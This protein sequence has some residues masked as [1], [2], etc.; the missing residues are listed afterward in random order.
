MIFKNMYCIEIITYIHPVYN[1]KTKYISQ[2]ATFS[3]DLYATF[4]Q[5]NDNRMNIPGSQ[6]LSRVYVREANSAATYS[7]TQ[8]PMH[9]HRYV[10][11]GCEKSPKLFI[12][13]RNQKSII[14][15]LKIPRS[16]TQ[17]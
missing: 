13:P 17:D 14:C 3:G 16:D 10:H 4:E 8:S 15:M 6:G 12:A 7:P 2:S 1:R 11:S 5:N 9:Y